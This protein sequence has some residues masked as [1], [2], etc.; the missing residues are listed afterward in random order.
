[1]VSQGRPGP[2]GEE[3]V[4][5]GLVTTQT[6]RSRRKDVFVKGLPVKEVGRTNQHN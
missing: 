4:S 1:M 2:P 5:R 3:A 6:K